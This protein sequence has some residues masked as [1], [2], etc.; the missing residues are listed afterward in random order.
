MPDTSETRVFFSGPGDGRTS[1]EMWSPL[2]SLPCQGH[3]VSHSSGPT[4]GAGASLLTWNSKL[5]SIC[6]GGNRIDVARQGRRFVYDLCSYLWLGVP[7]RVRVSARGLG[8]ASVT[9]ISRGRSTPEQRRN[10]TVQRCGSGRSY[11]HRWSPVCTGEQQ[12]HITHVSQSVL[13]CHLSH[14]SRVCR[15]PCKYVFC[16]G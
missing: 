10:E 6:I 8:R 13:K 2:Q 14:S 5:C 3:C 1:G 9:S 11:L 7:E 15:D 16:G 4:R 12:Y